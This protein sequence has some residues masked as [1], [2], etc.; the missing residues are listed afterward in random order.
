VGVTKP[1]CL[2]GGHLEFV[3][4]L[5]ELRLVVAK[6]DM[7]VPRS[8]SNSDTLASR[9]AFSRVA[10][11]AESR[12]AVSPAV[13]LSL[14]AASSTDA[15]AARNFSISASASTGLDARKS[16]SVAAVAAAVSAVVA[17]F[18]ADWRAASRDVR[19][20]ASFATAPTAATRATT[21]CIS[22]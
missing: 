7:V 22:S 14:S 12:V 1:R 20:D 17:R 19:A 3:G 10:A 21:S 11:W 15:A 2:L 13:V 5:G 18:S 8:H 9:V 6:S 16:R 4:D